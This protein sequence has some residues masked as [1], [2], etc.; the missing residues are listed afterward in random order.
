MLV[1]Q[2]AVNQ[3]WQIFTYLGM[4]STYLYHNFVLQDTTLMAYVTF[5]D[6]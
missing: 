3:D 5:D 4:I 1:A 6:C 2:V